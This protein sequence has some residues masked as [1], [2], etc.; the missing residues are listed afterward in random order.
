MAAF[1]ESRMFPAFFSSQ[2]GF[3]APYR[4]QDEEEAAKLI[5]VFQQ[6]KAHVGPGTEGQKVESFFVVCLL[7]LLLFFFFLRKSL[8]L[9][10][11]TASKVIGGYKPLASWTRT[12]P[13]LS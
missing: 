6:G 1:G 2:S 3:Q 12:C 5:G 9:I 13:W 8:L 4:V 10:V 11:Q 7:L